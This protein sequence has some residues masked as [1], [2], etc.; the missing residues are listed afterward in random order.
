MCLTQNSCS[1]KNCGRPSEMEPSH[2]RQHVPVPG[3][4]HPNSGPECVWV[5]ACR[6]E[7][8][9]GQV[10]FSLS[11]FSDFRFHQSDR[12]S[13]LFLFLSFLFLFFFASWM[14]HRPISNGHA[15]KFRVA[16]GFKNRDAS[17]PSPWTCSG[18]F[19]PDS[20]IFS[21]VLRSLLYQRMLGQKDFL[22][23][24]HPCSFSHAF[25]VAASR[26]FYSNSINHEYP[27]CASS[28]ASHSFPI[29]ETNKVHRYRGY[30]RASMVRDRS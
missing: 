23:R 26:A 27:I 6:R 21:R 5:V 1:G 7:W 15:S 3:L 29:V 24:T 11:F 19:R 17:S 10:L 2:H 9:G 25:R 28:K 18:R 22:I 8:A 14:I 20:R 4:A 16:E 13:G 12:N 30:D